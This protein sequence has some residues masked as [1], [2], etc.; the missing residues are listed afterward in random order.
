MVLIL[1]AAAV[2]A[3]GYEV[4]RTRRQRR[5]EHLQRQLRSAERRVAREHQA[6]RRAMN[7]AAG[8]SWRN[9]VE[10]DRGGA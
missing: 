7:E 9:L 4:L 6:A 3:V 8:Q 1:L 5:V 2:G 10:R